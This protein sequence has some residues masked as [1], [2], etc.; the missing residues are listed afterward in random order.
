MAIGHDT[1]QHVC[2]TPF[3]SVETSSFLLVRIHQ[4]LLGMH[5]YTNAV[6]SFYTTWE[7]AGR[8][9]EY[10]A[11]LITTQVASGCIEEDC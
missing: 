10:F 4:L 5:L 3:V 9:K 8:S 6:R 2:I 1:F 7:Y 11:Y